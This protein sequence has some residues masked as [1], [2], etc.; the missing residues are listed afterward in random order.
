MVSQT[1][2][3][4]CRVPVPIPDCALPDS[5]QPIGSSLCGHNDSQLVVA[6]VHTG[7]CHPITALCAAPDRAIDSSNTRVLRHAAIGCKLI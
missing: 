7:F 2:W 5:I 3:T 6:H 4:S 1:N